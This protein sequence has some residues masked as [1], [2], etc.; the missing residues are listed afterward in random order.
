MPETNVA[1][2]LPSRLLD[3]LGESPVSGAQLAE[4]LQE[5]AQRVRRT[6]AQMQ[7]EGL[8]TQVG[9]G[10]RRLTL[11]ELFEQEV[12][13]GAVTYRLT[14]NAAQAHVVQRALELLARLGMGQLGEIFEP[15]RWGTLRR[16]D[17]SEVSAQDI[18]DAE[19]ALQRFKGLVVGMPSTGYR[20]IGSSTVPELA[21]C[22]WQASVRLRHRLAWDGEPAG[23]MGTLFD[24][25]LHQQVSVLWRVS[26]QGP[27][28]EKKLRSHLV[29]ID[30]NEQGRAL[31]HRALDTHTRI[32]AADYQVLVELALT[33]DLYRSENSPKLDAELV[34]V[35][36]KQMRDMRHRLLGLS[37]QTADYQPPA[38]VGPDTAEQILAGLE[39]LQGRAKLP[40][41]QWPALPQGYT[42]RHQADHYRLVGPSVQDDAK[43]Y[44]AHSHSLQTLLYIAHNL[45]A[46]RQSRNF[47]SGLF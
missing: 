44:K 9:G 20:S 21:T 33:G 13:E 28:S 4:Q 22:A 27:L 14:L 37:E 35:L 30:M 1:A 25:P 3:L 43:A 16:P 2:N 8:V 6:L 12:S 40:E 31:L 11:A 41:N 24:E 32:T 38:P 15:V 46:G 45:V 7:Q 29:F 19:A 34:V 18:H 36:E 42:I 23:A 39:P 10:W 17:G 26:S 47:K 5:P